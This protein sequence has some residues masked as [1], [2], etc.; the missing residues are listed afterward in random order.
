MEAAQGQ[1][2]DLLI[3]DRDYGAGRFDRRTAGGWSG[4]EILDHLGGF[5]ARQPLIQALVAVDQSFVVDPQHVEDGCVEVSNMDRI[6]HDV[7][8]EIIRLS[9]DRASLDAATSHPHGEA[10]GMVVS[11]VIVLAESSLG[12]D[13]P[14]E[15]TAPEDQCGVE[16]PLVLQVGDQTIGSLI[17]IFALAWQ[18]S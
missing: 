6:L 7:V 1:P 16:H 15:F 9:V 18:T 10:S 12:V 17:D 14:T 13:R 11:S 2:A 8:G 4:Q 5:H 3:G